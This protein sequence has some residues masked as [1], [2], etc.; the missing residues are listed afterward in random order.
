M[1]N[2][3]NS[4]FRKRKIRRAWDKFHSQLRLPT[5]KGIKYYNFH[6]MLTALTKYFFETAHV[7]DHRIRLERIK[8][9]KKVGIALTKFESMTEGSVEFKLLS[10]AEQEN[11]LDMESPDF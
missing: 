8:R 10:I 7:R 3:Q 11:F 4:A 1:S 5:Y 6:D 9:N 2:I